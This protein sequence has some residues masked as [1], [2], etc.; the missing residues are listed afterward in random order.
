LTTLLA[1]TVV[2]DDALA[3]GVI[4]VLLLCFNNTHKLMLVGL[5]KCFALDLLCHLMEKGRCHH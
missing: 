3:T 4:L 2:L 5:I 1:L